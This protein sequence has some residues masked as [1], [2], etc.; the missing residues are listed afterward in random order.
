M[1]EKGKASFIVSIVMLISG[2]TIGFLLLSIVYTGPVWVK[3][4]VFVV[5]LFIT[6]MTIRFSKRYLSTLKK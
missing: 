4:V 6:A 2:M 3:V 1:A 5:Y